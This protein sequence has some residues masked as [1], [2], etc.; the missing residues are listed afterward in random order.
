MA[1]QGAKVESF[2]PHPKIFATLKKN[3]G[4]L[5]NVS[6][7]EFALSNQEGSFDLYIPKDFDRNEGRAS[8][9]PMENSETIKIPTKTIDQLF[10]GKTIDV[11]KI[12]VEGNELEVFKGAQKTLEEKRIKNILFE[13]F[14]GA[15]SAS[16]LFL[17]EHGYQVYRLGKG[18]FNLQ[19]L[20]PEEGEKLPLWEPSNYIATFDLTPIER[21]TSWQSFDKKNWESSRRSNSE[22]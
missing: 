8:L 6:L 2:E 18:Y 4:S 21:H 1:S 5:E 13:E 10:D 11:M 17:K 19:C 3:A 22:V 9:K 7:N 12:D 20:S 16:I 14:G 15:Q